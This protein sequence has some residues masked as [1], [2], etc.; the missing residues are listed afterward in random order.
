[1][2]SRLIEIPRREY[3]QTWWLLDA[4]DSEL[5]LIGTEVVDLSD[6]ARKK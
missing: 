6:A 4:A 2:S 5:R 1:M 3:P